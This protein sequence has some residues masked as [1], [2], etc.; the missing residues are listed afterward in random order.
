MSS[1]LI[2]VTH[3]LTLLLKH[4]QFENVLLGR[5]NAGK[6]TL[7]N[8]IMGQKIAKVSSAPGK[9]R[10]YNLYYQHQQY[11]ADLPG[12]GYA[13]VSHAILESLQTRVRDYLLLRKEASLVI[14]CMDIRHPWLEWDEALW[15]VYDSH[16]P[17]LW[18]LTKADK[19]SRQQAG[20]ALKKAE[21][22]RA[23]IYITF[24]KSDHISILLNHIKNLQ[25]N[26]S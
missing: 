14:H 4:K 23:G 10:T 13:A 3:D 1:P 26:M 25:A 21:N 15:D 19:L 17:A 24:G 7:I 5:S 8:R 12:V 20:L 2:Q 11:W 16:I 9:T 18:I 22:H 6:S